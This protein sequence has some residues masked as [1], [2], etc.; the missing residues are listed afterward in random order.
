METESPSIVENNVERIGQ[1]LYAFVA[2]IER[3]AGQAVKALDRACQSKS[4]M[5]AHYHLNA[6]LSAR[7]AVTR[8][9][10][11]KPRPSDRYREESIRRGK[12]LRAVLALD[13]DTVAVLKN[14]DFRNHFEHYDQRLDIWAIESERHNLADTNTGPVTM[15]SGIEPTDVLRHFVPD[16]PDIHFA[17]RT[18]QL[19][20]IATA[21][22]HLRDAA[23]A[24]DPWLRWPA[25]RPMPP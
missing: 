21:L 18:E 5:E 19:A 15:I 12:M 7:T 22:R 4:S 1:C 10:W 2:E 6:F 13:A 14:Q 16:G 9:L 11:P 17:G 23:K 8:L 24:Q 25:D 20:P 3:Q